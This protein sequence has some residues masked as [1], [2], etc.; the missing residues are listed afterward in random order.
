MGNLNHPSIKFFQ[1]IKTHGHEDTIRSVSATGGNKLLID[2]DAGVNTYHCLV[3]NA[4]NVQIEFDYSLPGY[5]SGGHDPL[6]LRSKG[7]SGTIILENPADASSLSFHSTTPIV[8]SIMTPGGGNPSFSTGNGAIHVITFT[9]F[10]RNVDS[11][12]HALINY[13][14]GFS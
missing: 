1:R 4:A 3:P 2:L 8:G 12:P 14:G 11:N 9:I 13:V 7:Q 10:I 6:E 5:P